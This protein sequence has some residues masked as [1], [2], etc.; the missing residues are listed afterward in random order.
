[1]PKIVWDAGHGGSNSTPGK[2]TPDGEYEWTFN[3]RVVRAG[4]AYLAKYQGVEQLRV[5]DMTG[6]TDVPLVTRTNRANNWNADIYVSVHHNALNGVY[7]S[8]TGTETYVMTPRAIYPQ[9]VRLAT[10]IHPKVVQAMAIRDRGIKEANFHVL[11]E[12]D[13]P[14]VLVEC[15][16]MDSRIDIVRMRNNQVLRAAGEAIAKGIVE[17]FNLVIIPETGEEDMLEKA[18]VINSFFDYPAAEAVAN[19]LNVPIYPRSALTA[20]AARELIVIGGTADGIQA[21]MITLLSGED[22]FETS[23]KVRDYLNRI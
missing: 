9:A 16:F 14:A 12:T 20:G 6:R 23:I 4:I 15:G 2:R 5:D 13:M 19:R 3:D 18:I 8:H 7:G 17:F 11:R 21:S 1:M 22:R 10:A